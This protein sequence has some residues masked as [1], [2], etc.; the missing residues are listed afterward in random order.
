MPRPTPRLASANVLWRTPL[1]VFGLALLVTGALAA[2]LARSLEANDR[3]GFDTEV[4]RTVDAIRERVDTTVT[5]LRGAAGLF[6]AHHD[7]DRVAFAAYVERLRLRERYP[8]VLGIGFAR[9]V[10][11]GD[12]G[13]VLADMRAQGFDDFHLWPAAQGALRTTIVYLEPLDA[14]NRAALGFDMASEPTRRAAMEAARDAGVVRA[15]GGVTLVQE[16]TPDKQA[17]FL[18]YLPLYRGV[19]A[20]PPATLAE[21]RQALHGYVYSALRVADLLRGVAGR[22]EGRID[23]ALFD[24]GPGDPAGTRQLLYAPPRPHASAAVPRY[25]AEHTIEVEGRRW[26]LRFTS[27]PGDAGAAQRRMLPF[28]AFAAFGTSALLGAITLV[29]ARR[30]RDAERA[31]DERSRSAAA[32][33]ASEARERERA[34][35]AE[36]LAA[37]LRADDARKD[38]FIATLAHELRNP[39]APL[40]TA[41]E[42]LRRVPTGERAERARALAERQTA[43]MVRL[44][45]DLLDVARIT[46]GAIALRNEPVP[47]AAVLEAA[48]EASQPLMEARAHHLSVALPPPACVV[49]GDPARLAQVFANLLN[50]AANYTPEGGHVDVQAHCDGPQAVVSVRD[51]GIGIAADKLPRVFDM[52]MQV[53]RAADRSGGLGIGLTLVRRLVELHG[54]RVEAHSA[55]P[56]RGSEFRVVLPLVPAAAQRAPDEAAPAATHAPAQRVLVVDDNV[57]AA[58]SLAQML[59]LDGH[60]V[61]LAHDGASGLRCAARWRPHAVLLDLGL[62]DIDGVEVARRLRAA[63]GGAALRLVAITG[64]G[65]A[66]DQRRTREAG[67]DAHLV[68]PVRYEEVV[69]QLGARQAPARAAEAESP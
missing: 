27:R 34:R 31:A 62:P 3:A 4:A 47:L 33:Q 61:E 11:A 12:D 42:I 52:F 66:A 16:I 15:S 38:E 54:G 7:V 21:R 18:I 41:L 59:A 69:A 10:A 50:N 1:L 64:W 2:Y 17:G 39:L 26:L 55:G 44:I 65:Q 9:V 6:A 40:R 29:Q 24:D 22:G 49:Q 37:E 30:R 43:Q 51:D 60:Q 5:L 68:K 14:R 36:A 25:V 13:P 45:D 48:V 28:L 32:L 20:D 53:K 35:E 19:Q 8:G 46:R 63:E 58:E 57:D 67:F 23:Y 56:G